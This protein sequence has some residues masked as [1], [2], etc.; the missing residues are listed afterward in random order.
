MLDVWHVSDLIGDVNDLKELLLLNVNN[1]QKHNH[2]QQ[3]NQAAV[4]VSDTA[5][6]GGS[7]Q[8]SSEV[9]VTEG[10]KI[11]TDVIVIELDCTNKTVLMDRYSK[12][13]GVSE[14]DNKAKLSKEIQASLKVLS[15][16]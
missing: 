13:L 2:N 10:E 11:E 3:H 7:N 6:A 9:V 15:F 12:S 14:S 5:G 1:Q 8:T 16:K 4:A